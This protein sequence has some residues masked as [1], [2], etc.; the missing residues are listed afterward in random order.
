MPDQNQSDSNSAW[1]AQRRRVGANPGGC[2]GL[3]LLLFCV[4]LIGGCGA[5]SSSPSAPVRRPSPVVAQAF[6]DTVKTLDGALSITLD[7]TPGH[8]GPNVFQ[9]RVLNS[10]TGQQVTRATITLYFTM[11]DMSMGTDS[12]ALRAQGKDMFSAAS[13]DLSM[14]G[15]WAIGITI[16]T[17]DQ[18]IHKAGISLV[19][20]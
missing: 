4:G 14:G 10:R 15:H 20:P 1:L 16:Q 17:P 9:M 3:A 11:Q 13:G 18:H 2:P 6:H 12:I 19:T 7:I 5:L 8:A